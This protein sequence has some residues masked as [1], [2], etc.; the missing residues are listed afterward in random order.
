VV[1]RMLKEAEAAY[2][3]RHV[4]LRYFNAVGADPDGE[5]GELQPAGNPFIAGPHPRL[6]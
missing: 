2:G 5:L 4:A 3:I 6:L 1:E